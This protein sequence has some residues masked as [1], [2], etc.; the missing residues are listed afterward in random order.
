MA[1]KQQMKAARARRIAHYL[2]E[3]VKAMIDGQVDSRDYWSGNPS[4]EK[5]HWYFMGATEMSSSIVETL[6]RRMTE[7]F[8]DD[9][10]EEILSGVE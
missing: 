3:D 5:H 7:V 8:G 9:D 1:T 4:G 6:A 10:I 2:A